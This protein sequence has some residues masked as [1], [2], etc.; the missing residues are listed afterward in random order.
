MRSEDP[1]PREVKWGERASLGHRQRE[2]APTTPTIGLRGVDLVRK[3]FFATPRVYKLREMARVYKKGEDLKSISASFE[4][5][6][7]KPRS[8]SSEGSI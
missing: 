2:S 7:L 5:Q 8:L 4:N 1:H 6:V 3:D